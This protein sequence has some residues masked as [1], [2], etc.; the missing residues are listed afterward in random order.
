MEPPFALYVIVKFFVG[1]VLLNVNAVPPVLVWEEGA[2]FPPLALNVTVNGVASTVTTISPCCTIVLSLS[3]FSQQ[4]WQ[5][6][7]IYIK[8]A[9][10]ILATFCTPVMASISIKAAAVILVTS[11]SHSTASTSTRAAAVILAMSSTHGMAS[12]YTRAAAAILATSSLPS[13]ASMSTRGA[14]AILAILL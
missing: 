6:I 12:I 10:V 3:F 2:P 8:V 9:A 4:L 14:V 7:P 5:L 1:T 13:T 11:S